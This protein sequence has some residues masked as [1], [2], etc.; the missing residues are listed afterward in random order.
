MGAATLLNGNAAVVF[1]GQGRMADLTGRKLMKKVLNGLAFAALV[2]LAT[3]V[4]AQAPS[5]TPQAP[6][7]KN[8]PAAAQQVAPAEPGQPRPSARPMAHGRYGYRM[9]RTCDAAGRRE[10]T[11]QLKEARDD[12]R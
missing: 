8:A 2:A 10:T 5:G 12:D 1:L 6:A 4:G 11:N 9:H 3:P 7:S